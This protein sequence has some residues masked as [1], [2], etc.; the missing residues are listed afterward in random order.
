MKINNFIKTSQGEKSFYL[1]SINANEFLKN[2]K[3]DYFNKT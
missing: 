1:T 3:I 2:S